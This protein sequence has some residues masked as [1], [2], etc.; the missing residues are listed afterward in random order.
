M[1]KRLIA[2]IALQVILLLSLVGKYYSIAV[3]GTPVTLKTA[4]VDPTDLFYGDYVI[5]R[6]EISR[7]Q[8]SAVEHD[9]SPGTSSD[10]VYVLLEK[11]GQ[12][13]YEATG[14]F[15]KKP[16]P[17]EGQVI[18][19]AKLNYYSA[20]EGVFDLQYGIER[21]YVEENT[22]QKYEQSQN[23]SLVDIRVSKGGEAVIEQLRP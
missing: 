18:L 3:G 6:Y 16:V 5:L 9:F 15:Q 8:A 21:Y 10:H 1:K 23:L 19:K 22:G 11:K 14:V 17:K 4:P 2:L 20:R 7:I 12:P 13:Y